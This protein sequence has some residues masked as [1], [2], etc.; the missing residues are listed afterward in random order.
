MQTVQ[1]GR[2]KEFAKKKMII[3]LL[4]LSVLHSRTILQ[5]LR[6]F[7]IESHD[8]E[9]SAICFNKFF[10]VTECKYRRKRTEGEKM[11]SRK[12]KVEE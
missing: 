9:V 3:G 11:S 8:H 7:L 1:R 4:R 12:E 2:V 5:L 10:R 6:S